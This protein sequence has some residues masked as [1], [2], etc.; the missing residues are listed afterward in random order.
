MV[1]AAGN[2]GT[3]RP[4]YPAAY[5]EVIAVAGADRSDSSYYRTNF[6]PHVDLAAP[7]V[8][9]ISAYWADGRSTYA[10]LSGTSMAAPHVAGT[11]AL[12]LALDPTLPLDDL[13]DVLF[14]GADDRGDLG[15]DSYFGHGRT[16]AWLTVQGVLPEGA[17]TGPEGEQTGQELVYLPAL[18]GGQ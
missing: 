9:I 16:N 12:A 17:S 8:E 15:W 5:D 18:M 4:F 3:D 1:A 11:A 6:G 7:A 2:D 10:I 13:V 14:A